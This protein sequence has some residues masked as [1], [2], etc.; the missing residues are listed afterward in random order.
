MIMA[1]PHTLTENTGSALAI[2]TWAWQLTHGKN[3]PLPAESPYDNESALIASVKELLESGKKKAGR[4]PKVLVIGAVSF[5]A[6]ERGVKRDKLTRLQLGRCGNGAV[7]LA[8]D[9]GIPD[10]DILKWDLE[11]T[12]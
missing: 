8:K 7:Q 12:K 9:V 6:S 10:G 1:M 3:E 5:F 2:K 11:E 4:S